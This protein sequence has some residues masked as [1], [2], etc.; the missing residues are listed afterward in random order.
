MK[1]KLL[2]ALFMLTASSSV[3]ATL[4]IVITGGV[5]SARPIAV[6]PFQWEGQGGMEVNFKVM[7]I[8]VPQLRD[9]F[10]GNTGIVH[11]TV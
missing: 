2:F 7:A 9:D 8:L 4:E 6:L 10:N 3:M 5:D 1:I 11:G